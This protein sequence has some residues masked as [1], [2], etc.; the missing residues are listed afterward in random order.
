MPREQ[1][2]VVLVVCLLAA[3]CIATE[4]EAAAFEQE[5]AG[6]TVIPRGSY[7]AVGTLGNPCT[8]SLVAPDRVLTAAHCVCDDVDRTDCNTRAAFILR[9][10]LRK[11]DP[12]TPANE[13]RTRGDVLILASTRVHP[14][15]GVHGWLRH[16]YA[17]LVLDR[18][19]TSLAYVTPMV[20][21]S[22]R[23]RVGE[24][25]T[26]VGYGPSSASGGG[27][28][29]EY[30]TKR[31]AAIELDLVADEGGGSIVLAYF[32][33]TIFTC[34]GDS[35]GPAINA[36]GRIVGVASSGNGESNSSYDATSVVNGWL[37]QN[38][39]NVYFP[40]PPPPASCPS[41]ERCCEPLPDGGCGLCIPSDL[42]CF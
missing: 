14:L 22:R 20:V 39:V 26:L 4:E 38:G 30:G 42:D 12:R 28:S 32:H 5:I 18:V 35:G 34:P 29:S 40:P 21:D 27:C 1:P 6:G 36:A 23:P 9:D 3:S 8:A 15:Y 7:E 31:G 37:V 13:D 19:A 41:G 2:L 16:D 24:R 25:H 17:V 10:V 33:N 11:D